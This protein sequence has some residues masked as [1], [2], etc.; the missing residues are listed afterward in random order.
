MAF[1]KHLPCPNC[2]S[3]D[4]LAEYVDH[5]YCFGCRHW[6]S[7]NDLASIRNRLLPSA[8]EELDELTV[9]VT[10]DIP[11]KAMEWLLQYGLTSQ[12]VK[13]YNFGW[14]NQLQT[15]MLINTPDYYQGRNF[16]DVGA[17]YIS[18]G[19]KPLQFYGLG[20]TLVC[21]ED[22]ISAVK[23]SKSN[24]NYI[25]VPL[26]GSSM[27]LKLTETILERFKKVFLWLDRDKATEAVKMARNLKQKNIDARVVITDK[28][29]KEY[30]LQ[31]IN[32]IIEGKL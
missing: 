22:I 7:K 27:P 17:K 11:S 3:R 13:A 5:F 18:R 15:L 29:P 20:D 26:L 10:Q 12:D 14:S 2:G 25:S 23:V 16:S 24:S 21:V 8:D 30:N 9:H 1:I 32:F 19:K 31:D 4:N 28:D 6:K